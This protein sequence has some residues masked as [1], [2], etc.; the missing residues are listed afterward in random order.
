[1]VERVRLV[2]SVLG[3]L[4]IAAVVALVL[5]GSAPVAAQTLP[6]VEPDPVADATVASVP[7]PPELA[8]PRA[9]FTTFLDAMNAAKGGVAGALEDAVACFELDDIPS[10]VRAEVGE[11]AARDLKTYLDKTELIV[12]ET[13]PSELDEALFVWRRSASGEVSLARQVDGS[14]L[15]SRR[16]RDALGELV[17]SVR[18]KDFVEGLEGGGAPRR[19][20]DVVRDKLPATMQKRAFLFENWQWLGLLAVLLLGVILDRILRF[21]VGVRVHA[22]LEKRSKRLDAAHA[23]RFQSPVGVLAMSILWSFLL[24]ML[25]LPIGVMTVLGTAV[26]L[27]MGVAAVWAAYRLVDLI[28]AYFGSIA[29]E[30]ESKLDDLI[31][32][33]LRRAGKVIVVAFGVVFVAQNLD[34]DISTF[35]TA[36]GL[37]GLAVSLAAKDTVENLFGSLTV[38]ADRPFQIGDWI[39]LGELEGTVVDVGIRSTKIR[40]FYNSVISVPNSQLVSSAVDNLGA[41]QWRRIKCHLSVTYDTSPEKI[42]AFC[43]GIRELVRQHPYTR[44]DYY[45][46][47]LHQF[48]GSGL[49]ILL[50]V[51]H[52]APNWTTELRERHRLFLDIIRLAGKLGVEFAFPTQT[53]HIASAPAG[54]PLGAASAPE[55][56]ATAAPNAEAYEE[57][58]Q[59]GRR[60]AEAIVRDAWGEGTQRPVDFGDRERIRPAPFDEK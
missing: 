11:K 26:R 50:Y 41:R 17:D 53:L 46:V 47:Y 21:L 2:G 20:A 10:A 52:E 54:S 56:A 45:N 12:L 32:P 48:G 31:V 40:T 29:D 16:T 9:T 38:I 43:E 18:G 42:E 8:S 25:D 3:T 39:V 58:A 49:D 57:I 6:G 1:M 51:F 27:V 60:E 59:L 23:R 30:T 37:G 55:A 24:P 14:W 34:L 35:L 19:L 44:K 7:A 15:F 5:V 13:L 28:A 22:L 36:L 33:L 4:G